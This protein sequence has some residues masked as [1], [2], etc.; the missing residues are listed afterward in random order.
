M[1]LAVILA[2]ADIFVNVA[3]GIRLDEPASDLALALALAS[4]LRDRPLPHDRVLVGE[5]GLG[6]ELRP[7]PQLARRLAE[8]ARLGFRQAFVPSRLKTNTSMITTQVAHVSELT[9]H[10]AA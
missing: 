3:G 9:R 4:S 1:E 10:L 6:G 8:A 7:V 2:G 5:V